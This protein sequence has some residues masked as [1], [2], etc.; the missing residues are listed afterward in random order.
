MKAKK[1]EVVENR[2]GGKL[3]CIITM[4]YKMALKA[5]KQLCH[6]VE[7]RRGGELIV[8]K[9]DMGRERDRLFSLDFALK[10]PEVKLYKICRAIIGCN[11]P[12][13]IKEILI[14]F[15][16]IIIMMMIMLIDQQAGLPVGFVGR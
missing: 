9:R 14:S 5:K 10:K 2:P 4:Y 13:M 3:I 6:V 1:Q 7:N 11:L 15:M 8:L 16:N 12:L